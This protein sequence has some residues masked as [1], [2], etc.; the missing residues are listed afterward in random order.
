MIIFDPDPFYEFLESG[1]GG[2][3]VAG[4]DM[5]A[6]WIFV[7][8]RRQKAP[9]IRNLHVNVVGSGSV[10]RGSAYGCKLGSLC[11]GQETV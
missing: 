8:V 7:L 10:Q 9:R 2:L 4:P 11:I 6:G 3:C 5:V 1:S